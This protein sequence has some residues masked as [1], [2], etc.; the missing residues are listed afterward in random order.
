MRTEDKTYLL[1]KEENLFQAALDEFSSK[2]FELASLNEII[3]KSSYNKGSFYYRFQTKEEVYHALIDYVYT[4]QIAIF[5]TLGVKL[6]ELESEEDLYNIAW[7]NLRDLYLTDHRYLNILN[8]I[9]KENNHI[10]KEIE[11]VCQESLFNRLDKRLHHLLNNY[12]SELDSSLKRINFAQFYYEFPYDFSDSNIDEKTENVTKY[13][14][15]NSIKVSNTDNETSVVNVELINTNLS[16]ILT[17]DLP[18]LHN[19]NLHYISK[20]MFNKELIHEIRD[21]LKIKKVDLTSIILQGV[22]KNLKD[23]THLKLLCDLDF[24]TKSYHL[25]SN[26]EKSILI[27]TYLVVTGADSI[28]FDYVT[29]SRKPSITQLLLDEILPLYAKTSKII[30]IDKEFPIYNDI[31]TKLYYYDRLEGL[32]LLSKDFLKDALLDVFLVTYMNEH[33]RIVSRR[34]LKD[35]FKFD[36]FQDYQMLNVTRM[37]RVRAKDTHKQE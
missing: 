18:V 10:K 27:G 13:L 20:E 12:Q 33:N 2:S 8:K 23:Y 28:I 34:V 15:G 26:I 17:E 25:L 30:V 7:S 35:K 3:K 36:D 6:Y 5:N 16:F 21:K 32:R 9:S 24:A 11:S 1:K 31:S 4:Q 14:M 19:S 37:A 22:T 29:E